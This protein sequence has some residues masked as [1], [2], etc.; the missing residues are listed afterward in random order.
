MLSSSLLLA[1][2]ELLSLI[3]L[4]LKIPGLVRNTYEPVAD[5]IIKLFHFRYALFTDSPTGLQSWEIETIVWTLES[6]FSNN[7][8]EYFTW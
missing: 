6:K 1:V 3:S 8:S 2:K 4:D 5:G 7:I